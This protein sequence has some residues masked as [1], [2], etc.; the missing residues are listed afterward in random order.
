MVIKGD[1]LFTKNKDDFEIYENG[2]LVIKNG[3]V[4]AVQKLYTGDEEVI[5]RAGKLIIPAFVDL[6]LHANQYANCGLGYD[7]ELLTWLEK[8]T[9]PEEV[10]FKD[11]AYAEEI[12]KEVLIKLWEAGSLRSVIFASLYKDAS[13]LM[14]KLVAEAGLSAYVG[15]VNMDRNVPDFYIESTEDSIKFS[16]D[17]IKEFSNNNLVKPI[18]TPRFVP[19]CTVESMQGQG[20]LAKKYN[21][22]VQSHMNESLAENAWVTELHP[23]DKTSTDVFEK[24]GLFGSNSKTIMAHCIHNTK[25]ELEL[26]KKRNFY[27]VHCPESNTNLTSGI[28]DVKGML[29]AG[30]PVSL[31]SDISGGHNIYMPKQ[32]ILAIQL[33][34]MKARMEDDLSKVLNLS[35][36]FYMATKSG[37]SFFGDTGSFEEGYSGDFLVIDTTSIMAPREK[38]SPIERLEKYLYIGSQNNITERYLQGKKLDK[39]FK[40]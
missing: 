37:G 16:E 4:K 40:E 26:M 8:Y 12:F 30:L 25:H 10:K 22:P 6:H 18:I 17:L 32:I 33:S 29:A 36:V 19:H 13:E 27:P 14:F 2:F 9:Y 20:S 3:K 31:G 28:M 11:L 7:E 24:Y 35:E 21:V 34:K 1:I 15:K 39:P 23:D 5:D 38:R